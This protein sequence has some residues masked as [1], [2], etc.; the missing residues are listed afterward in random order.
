M[1]LSHRTMTR[2]FSHLHM[3]FPPRLVAT[4]LALSVTS[5][6][7]QNQVPTAPPQPARPEPVE[8]SPA[9][10]RGFFFC[11]AGRFGAAFSPP[12]TDLLP[13]PMVPPVLP[14]WARRRG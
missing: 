8:G 11:G 9:A 10:R 7:T 13:L 1:P 2:P 4:P 14:A 5:M 3:P 12:P 6:V